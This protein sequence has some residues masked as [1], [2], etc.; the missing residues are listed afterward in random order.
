MNRWWISHSLRLQFQSQ[1]PSNP[2]LTRSTQIS[3]TSIPNPETSCGSRWLRAKSVQ[4]ELK[5]PMEPPPMT[6]LSSKTFLTWPIS[7]PP[8]R[9][10]SP[11]ILTVQQKNE[12]ISCCFWFMF[13]LFYFVQSYPN[14]LQSS[15]AYAIVRYI[16]VY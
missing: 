3:P 6:V 13:C 9:Y 15:K 1:P 2:A 7:S 14:P 16:H 12:V 11:L 10:P 4:S 5:P 8:C